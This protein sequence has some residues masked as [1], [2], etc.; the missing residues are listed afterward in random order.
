MEVSEWEDL[1]MRMNKVQDK[2]DY[3]SLLPFQL[4]V[5][6]DKSLKL[7]ESPS[8]PLTTRRMIPNFITVKSTK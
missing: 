8:L 4:C 7:S 5:V 1:Y 3:K 6:L 2:T